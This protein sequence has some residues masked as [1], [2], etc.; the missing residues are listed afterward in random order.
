MTES[1]RAYLRVGARMVTA[2][3]LLLGCGDPTSPGDRP[4]RPIVFIGRT[5][6]P[7][8]DV[9]EPVLYSVRSDG[10]GLRV[11]TSG[12]GQALNPAWSRDGTR[13]VFASGTSGGEELWMMNADGSNAAPAGA[14]LPT[15]VYSYTRITW[16]PAEDRVAAECFGET[17][18][19]TLATGAVSSLS[20]LSGHSAAYPDWSP[21]GTLLL[22]GDAFGSDAFTIRPDGGTVT[23]VLTEALEATWSPDGGRVAFLG[24]D[25]LRRQAIFVANADGSGRRQVTATDTSF[26]DQGPAWSPDGRWIAFHRRS[27]LC[28]D[29]GTPPQRACIPHWSLHVVRADGT[30]LRRLT[31]DN[32]QATRPAW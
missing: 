3:L 23:H 7:G 26:V 28:A 30:G 29:V 27:V 15:C 24:P 31:P 1:L 5:E 6:V 19:I 10:S 2:G 14:G 11:L 8:G 9:G 12:A 21:D 32:L 18:I 20:Q 4:E 13:I 16:A 25:S 22:F 17:S